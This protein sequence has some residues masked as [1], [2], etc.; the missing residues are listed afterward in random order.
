[1]KKIILA[2][3][4][5]YRKQLLQ[6]LGISFDCIDSNLD[7]SILKAK[8]NDPKQLTVE[9]SCAKAANISL[10]GPEYLIIGSDQIAHKD[11]QI[12]GKAG[13]SEAARKQLE[14][15]QGSWHELITSYAILHK[16]EFISKTVMTKLK[17][18]KL[19]SAQIKYYL[20][21]DNPIDCAGSYKLE[22]MGISLFEKIN[23]PDHTAIIGLPL[24]ELGNDLIELGVQIPP[25]L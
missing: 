19:T 14:M 17:M 6:R 9:L 11:G 12:L 22:L 20:R 21:N 25:E 5:P 15:L 10:K 1:M 8:I 4:S 7:E 24:I 16:N 23:T 18:R 2:S 13:S 3:S